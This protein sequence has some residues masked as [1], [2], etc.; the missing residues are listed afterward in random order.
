M[1]RHVAVLFVAA[2]VLTTVAGAATTLAADKTHEGIVVSVGDGNL[3]MTDSEGKNE[4][5]HIVAS[6]VKITLDGASAKLA[7]LKSLSGNPRDA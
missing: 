3:T 4:H 6:T 7:D 2:A 1:F 5:M